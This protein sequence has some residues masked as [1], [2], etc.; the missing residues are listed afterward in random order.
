MSPKILK[1][2]AVLGLGLLAGLIVW[3]YL[4]KGNPTL[5]TPVPL[6]DMEVLS[7]KNHYSDALAIAQDWQP[8]AY[9]GD[10]STRV[11]FQD[12]PSRL[13]IDYTFY[14]AKVRREALLVWVCDDST[15]HTMTVDMTRAIG[16]R[17]EI[18]NEEWVL[19]S[20]QALQIAFENGGEDYLKHTASFDIALFLEYQKRVTN[21]PVVW[22]VSFLRWT[23]DGGN[24]HV[25]VN[26]V[27][28]EVLKMPDE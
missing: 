26:A 13:C 2:L 20:T 23:G 16:E 19:D 6:P 5:G 24:L 4:D 27:T 8:D 17:T 11:R 21:G 10:A 28:G 25:N 22:R 15:S 9:L 7:V 14:S 1:L 3:R 12:K 18:E